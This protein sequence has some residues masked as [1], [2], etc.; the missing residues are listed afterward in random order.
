MTYHKC[1]ECKHLDENRAVKTLA[2][3]HCPQV[4]ILHW[5]LVRKTWSHPDWV[6]NL[7]EC[8]KYF[9]ER[10]TPWPIK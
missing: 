2:F 1:R 10:E 6:Y 7:Y 3:V 8:P 4:G 5:C 9:E